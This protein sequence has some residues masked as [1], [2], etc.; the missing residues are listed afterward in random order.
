[1]TPSRFGI[2]LANLDP[3]VGREIAKLRSAVMGLDSTN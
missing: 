2:Y 1:M 3:I